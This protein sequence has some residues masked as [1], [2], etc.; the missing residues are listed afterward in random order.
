MIYYGRP[1]RTLFFEGGNG[2][3]ISNGGQSMR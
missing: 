1:H 2:W 3:K